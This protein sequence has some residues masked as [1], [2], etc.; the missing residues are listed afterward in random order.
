[1]RLLPSDEEQPVRVNV[2]VVDPDRPDM[3]IEPLLL[4]SAARVTLVAVVIPLLP[5]V[6]L[7]PLLVRVPPTVSLLPPLPPK[8]ST[9]IVPLLVSPP[10]VAPA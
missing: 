4:V 6:K 1:M 9:S 8:E 10:V 2:P 5:I 7:K 3:P